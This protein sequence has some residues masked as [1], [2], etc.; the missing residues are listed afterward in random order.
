[1]KISELT[2]S[3]TKDI[4]KQYFIYNPIVKENLINSNRKIAINHQEK[5]K[6]IK[7]NKL[8]KMLTTNHNMN[9]PQSNQN[10]RIK[11]TTFLNHIKNS[12]IQK[13]NKIQ[14]KSEKAKSQ[15]NLEINISNPISYK[16]GNLANT[17][18]N[19][20]LNSRNS[21]PSEFL[22]KNKINDKQQKF[23]LFTHTKQNLSIW[24]I[25]QGK[26]KEGIKINNKFKANP[27]INTYLIS[28]EE[29]QNNQ[30]DIKEEQFSQLNIKSTMSS[31]KKCSR[32]W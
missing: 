32:R 15:S 14:L 4:P 16:Y 1:M 26:V 5:E 7:L 25:F 30:N 20:Y 8:N 22:F 6:L 27:K 23:K 10:K 28:Y 21:S 12:I 18:A 2:K 9:N 31:N 29:S 11:K 24:K 3:T 17:T 13:P 19:T